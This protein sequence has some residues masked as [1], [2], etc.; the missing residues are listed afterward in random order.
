MRYSSFIIITIIIDITETSIQLP[1]ILLQDLS[2][3]SS[4]DGDIASE[5]AAPDLPR[6][7]SRIPTKALSSP[8]IGVGQLLELVCNFATH[9]SHLLIN[10]IYYILI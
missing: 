7:V 4:V 6:F 2:R 3:T 1:I 9:A 10:D 5:S 8:V